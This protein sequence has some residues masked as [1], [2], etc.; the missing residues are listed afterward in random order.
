MVEEDEDMKF[1]LGVSS[2]YIFE[3]FDLFASYRILLDHTIFEIFGSYD[4]SY[5]Q[6]ETFFWSLLKSASHQDYIILRP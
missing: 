4:G 2:V 5:D 3:L 1:S 6:T